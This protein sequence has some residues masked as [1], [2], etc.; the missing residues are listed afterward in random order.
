MRKDIYIDFPWKLHKEKIKSVIVKEGIK[1]IG[2]Y[3]FSSCKSLENVSIPDSVTLIEDGAFTRCD[4]IKKV[5]LPQNVNS[6]GMTAFASCVGLKEINIP[7]S[8]EYIGNSDNLDSAANY[9]VETGVM[10]AAPAAKMA[11]KN[12]GSAISYIDGENMKNSLI[13]FYN[14]LGIALPSDDFYYEK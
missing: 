11:L 3:A 1:N 9:V 2:P 6:L 12:L 8:V 10:A 7:D 14:A 5:T 4:S 13:G